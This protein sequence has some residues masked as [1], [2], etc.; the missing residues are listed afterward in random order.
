MSDFGVKVFVATLPLM[1]YKSMLPIERVWIQENTAAQSA[2]F[3]VERLAL[4]DRIAKECKIK[5]KVEAFQELSSYEMGYT[6]AANSLVAAFV[7]LEGLLNPKLPPKEDPDL[8]RLTYLIDSRLVKAEIPAEF[9]QKYK[10]D[11]AGVWTY[12]HTIAASEAIPEIARFLGA[13][14]N[15]GIPQQAPQPQS[16]GEN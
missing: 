9:I 13:E 15:G 12:A 10:L 2:E 8:L 6:N 3:R 1:S 4:I 11:W 5:T 14:S 16:V 7:E